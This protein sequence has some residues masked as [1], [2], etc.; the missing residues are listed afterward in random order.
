M[1]HKYFSLLDWNQYHAFLMLFA[2]II[3]V[4]METVF[5]ILLVSFGS[6]FSLVFNFGKSI[7]TYANWVTGLRLLLMIGVGY[8]FSVLNIYLIFTVLGVAILL[9]ILD[10]YLARKFKQNSV[11]GQYFDMEVDAFFVLLMSFYYYL[12][13][14]ISFWILLPGLMRYI[15][16]IILVLFPKSTFVE[17]KKTFAA[18]IA[19]S[20][21]VILLFG[22]LLKG[23]WLIYPLIIGASLIIFSFTVLFIE[24]VR[25]ESSLF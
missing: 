11:F 16:K 15:F 23:N 10:G 17:K 24:Y 7:N 21:F 9:D 18:F 5:P 13:R 1:Q 8:F 22:I 19:G 3:S 6:F 20:Y 25:H 4:Y 14:D 2:A 12:H